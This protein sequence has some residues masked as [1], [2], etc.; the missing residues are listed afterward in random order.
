MQPGEALSVPS[1]AEWL[2]SDE[3]TPAATKYVSN[4]NRGNG[5]GS[6]PANA[7]EVQAALNGASPGDVLLAVCQTPG[8]I[9]FWN[10]P[11]GLSFP[12]GSAGN[13]ITLQAR[14]GDGVVISA[15]EDF[16]GGAHA[17][18]AASGRRAASADDIDKNIWRSV[19]TFSGGAQTMM[20]RWI[21]F[22]HP[23][24]LM[25]YVNMTNLRAAYG[26]ETAR[27]T[28]P[29]PMVH[30]DS[31]G[32]VYI[33]MQKPHPVKYSRDNKWSR[34]NSWPGFPEAINNGQL[35]YPISQNP[36]DYPIYLWPGAA[37]DRP[38]L[39]RFRCRRSPGI[40]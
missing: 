21:E 5:S 33:R 7:Q 26:Q 25:R 40:T 36:N 34:T 11:N 3:P 22:G 38:S 20:G 18:T 10:Y 12:S 28:M 6:S 35:N 24:Q 8:T 4:Q 13:Y 19:G 31:D 39:T 27:R 29:A 23:H 1:L 14:Q 17:R 2:V 30:K 15:G 37:S 16:R 32:R 9:E